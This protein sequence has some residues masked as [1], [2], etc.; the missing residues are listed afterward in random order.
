MGK[1]LITSN[2]GDGLY[3][4][5]PTYHRARIE[6]E[7][8]DLQAALLDIEALLIVLEAAL[9][10][11]EADLQEA[12]NG[13][14][15]AV[16]AYTAALEGEDQAAIA[17]ARD[18]VT[19]ATVNA[20]QLGAVRDQAKVPVALERA[21]RLT[22]QQRLTML[23]QIQL[24]KEQF[25]WCAD[26]TI[27]AS[28]EVATAE[29][30]G[31]GA[32]RIIIRPQYA[33]RG[34]YE[35]ERDG[36]LFHR[37]G[38]SSA[39]VF[40]NAAL[41]PGWQKWLPT[42]RVG[43]ITSIDYDADTCA[44]VLD[45]DSSSAYALP[46]NQLSALSG[47]PIVYRMCDADAFV[48][49]DRV[50]VEFQQRKWTFP[51][52]IG[53]ET[54]PKPC[55]QDTPSYTITFGIDYLRGLTFDGISPQAGIPAGGSTTPVTVF[56]P[57]IW[58]YD[59]SDEL[60]ERAMNGSFFAF[61]RWSLGAAW[62]DPV[63]QLTNV[64]ASRFVYAS[65]YPEEPLIM[66]R[67]CHTVTRH[68]FVLDPTH[69]GYTGVVPDV[70]TQIVTVSGTYKN[71]ITLNEWDVGEGFRPTSERSPGWPGETLTRRP[72]R[73]FS[74]EGLPKDRAQSIQTSSAHGYTFGDHW[75]IYDTSTFDSTA[76][77]TWLGETPSA[78][79]LDFVQGLYDAA[80][81]TRAYWIHRPRPGLQSAYSI[82]DTTT[83]SGRSIITGT[84]WTETWY[85][86]ARVG[87]W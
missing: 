86:W 87:E 61:A 33:G 62:T 19:T 36:Q 52:V 56:N 32:A 76:F 79:D 38:M 12:L 51:R 27:D 47:V 11:A 60:K 78:D 73:P 70:D 74:W 45:N 54:N 48:V 50:L 59:G 64:N 29:I 34:D 3:V 15:A 1:A 24:D 65:A 71:H 84:T 83:L 82:T 46:I 69:P 17:A 14:D 80:T 66:P 40:F 4:I 5:K 63:F 49:N 28:G 55:P 77:T 23:Q 22:T 16:A 2:A 35:L 42:Y 72:T 10:A 18:A 7:I 43:T 53:F 68:D 41:L 67:W 20:T 58:E 57:P 75:F 81:S 26:W 21:R 31:E 39:Q 13:V 30:P 8:A 44:V 9:D 6:D 85:V 37:P 25:A